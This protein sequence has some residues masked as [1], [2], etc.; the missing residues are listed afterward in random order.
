MP[1][2]FLLQ[3]LQKIFLIILSPIVH[4][5]PISKI[6]FELKFAGNKAEGQFSKRVFQENKTRQIFRKTNISYLLIRTYVC[7][8]GGKN[9]SFFRK[10]GVPCFLETPVLRFALLPYYRRV[11]IIHN[12]EI[13]VKQCN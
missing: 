4:I 3:K 7:V 12:L 8:S 5:Y 2:C 1:I 11:V 6:F 9:C 13:I 10:F